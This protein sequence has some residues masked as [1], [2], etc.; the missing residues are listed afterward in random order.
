MKNYVKPKTE[1][2]F[3]E[4]F[5]LIAKDEFNYIVNVPIE[6]NDRLTAYTGRYHS[7]IID[8]V[9][10]C[11]KFDFK[12][13]VLSDDYSMKNVLDII[14]H[15][16]THWEVNYIYKRELVAHGKEFIKHALTHNVDVSRYLPRKKLSKGKFHEAKCCNCDRVVVKSKNMKDL[17][18]YMNRFGG[19][20]CNC[21]GDGKRYIIDKGDK[22]IYRHGR[23]QG[24]KPV[25]E[26]EWND[27]L[28][29]YYKIVLCKENGNDIWTGTG[30]KYN[31]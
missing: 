9:P 10:T 31:R 8:K 14:R 23:V 13:I 15:E 26:E 7:K 21:G 12:P 27:C 24:W 18:K 11:I 5:K 22:L 28:L 17:K 19:T 25:D 30:V 2:E 1:S 6:F 16:L 4:L 20:I 29:E 3:I